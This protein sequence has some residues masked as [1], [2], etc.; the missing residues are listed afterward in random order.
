MPSWMLVGI[1]TAELQRGLLVSLFF[2]D[3]YTLGWIQRYPCHKSIITHIQ[4]CTPGLCLRLTEGE[5]AGAE[6][7]ACFSVERVLQTPLEEIVRSSAV[8]LK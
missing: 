8:P 4:L 7:T 6:N 1:V 3:F 5:E 2:R